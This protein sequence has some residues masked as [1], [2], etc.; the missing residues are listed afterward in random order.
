MATGRLGWTD[1]NQVSRLTGTWYLAIHAG[2]TPVSDGTGGNEVGPATRPAITFG[3]VVQDPAT[4]RHYQSNNA[5][6][7]IVLTNT[8]PCWISG[9]AIC[10]AAT[11]ATVQYTGIFPTPYQ[12]AKLATINIPA[13]AIRMYAEP[14]T[15]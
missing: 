1:A 10:S 8:A 15:I 14:A 3:A 4:Q 11:G 7:N 2:A 9:F 6:N 13:G 5:V 12:V